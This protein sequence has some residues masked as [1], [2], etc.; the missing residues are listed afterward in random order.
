MP[1][2][3]KARTA[4][5]RASEFA[6][7]AA[8]DACSQVGASLLQSG[9]CHLKQKLTIC[10]GLL[11]FALA[12]AAPARAQLVPVYRGFAA[13]PPYEIMAIV[14]D[15]GFDPLGRP[16]RRGPVYWVRALTPAGQQVRVVVNARMGRII[17]V[18]P[19]DM[20]YAAPMLPPPYARPPRAVA[21]PPR[22]ADP[23]MIAPDEFDEFDDGLRPGRYS[24]PPAP[25]RIG[26]PEPSVQP[27]I[28]NTPSKPPLPR[29]RPKLAAADPSAPP[30]TD[31]RAVNVK[32]PAAPGA[33]A[34]KPAASPAD[35][36]QAKP[37]ATPIYE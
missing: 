19:A 3:L 23:R 34:A 33:S 29:P 20:R 32:P 25:G 21:T 8:R 30:P 2:K 1:D 9:E 24:S 11:A 28:S 17:A 12:G 4:L 26:A 35:A 22:G 5:R 31:R 13:L 6:A 18:T 14:R 37:S 15:E 27:R 10:A 36:A 7:A 16:V